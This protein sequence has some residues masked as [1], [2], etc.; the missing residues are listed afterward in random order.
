MVTKSLKTIE[1]WK[2]IIHEVALK[3]KNKELRQ[4]EGSLVHET[5]INRRCFN[6]GLL[7]TLGYDMTRFQGD[8][9]KDDPLEFGWIQ[10]KK[11]KCVDSFEKLIGKQCIKCSKKHEE[12]EEEH[13]SLIEDY[14]GHLN[15]VHGLKNIK[16]EQ[17]FLKDL[18]NALK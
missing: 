18:E 17:Q 10:Y 4:I 5:D 1:D 12:W 8:D 7:C 16:L 11:L 3:F 6:G 2:K 9:P 13:F 15:D 14:I